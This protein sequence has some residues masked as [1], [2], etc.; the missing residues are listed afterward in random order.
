MLQTNDMGVLFATLQ[1]AYG[2]QWKHGA[3]SIPVWQEKLR[4]FERNDV[5]RAASDAIE[6]HPD[7]PPTVGQ[8]ISILKSYQPRRSTYLPPPKSGNMSYADWKKANGVE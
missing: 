8:I 2:N 6:K 3:D 1:A 4:G 7:F 5:M